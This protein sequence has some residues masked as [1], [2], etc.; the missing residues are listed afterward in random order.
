MTSSLHTSSASRCSI[1]TLDPLQESGW[2]AATRAHPACSVFHSAGWARVLHEC[3]GHT[4]FYL[5]EMEGGD[6]S[7]LLPLMEVNSRLTGRRGVSLPF[8]DECGALCFDGANA[9]RLLQHALDLGR[10]R[11]WKHLEVRGDIPGLAPAAPWATY[12]G[13]VLELGP[14]LEALSGGLDSSVRR[15]LRKAEKSGLQ[16]TVSETC[17]SVQNYYTL[18]CLTRRKH[19]VPPQPFTFFRNIFEHVIKAGHGF[20]VEAR[21]E[22]RIVAAGVFLHHGRAGIYKFGASDPTSL[23]LRGNDLVMWEAIKWYAAR[24][25]KKF[26]MGRTAAANEGLRRFKRGFGTRE[27]AIHYYRYDFRQAKFIQGK[28][29]QETWVNK[30]L[31]LTPLPVFRMMGTALYPHVD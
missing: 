1:R 30:F 17:E 5:G 15:A 24:G 11:Q 23:H 27:S 6:A 2:D 25:Y 9:S 16:A 4:P 21:H 28:E 8:S 3:Y 26:S 29:E 7:A 10:S 20:I 14:D 31:K 12:L 18:H 13:H 19:G 22:G